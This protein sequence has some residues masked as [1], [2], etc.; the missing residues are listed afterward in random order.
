MLYKNWI[1]SGFVHVK[2]LYIDGTFVSSDHVFNSLK[3]RRN[4]IIEYK[5]VKQVIEKQTNKFDVRTYASHEYVRK[6][7]MLKCKSGLYFIKDQKSCFLYKILIENKYERPYTEK[8]W[9]RLLEKEMLEHDWRN[10]Y[11]CRIHS[12][13]DNKL[14]GFMNTLIHNLIPCREMLVKWKKVTNNECPVC[15]V[16]ETVEHIYFE[17]HCIK[18]VWQAIGSKL[19]ID[20]TWTKVIMGYLLDIPVH[21]V[22]N[23]LF[24]MILYTRYKLWSRSLEHCINKRDNLVMLLYDLTQWNYII[25]TLDFDKNHNVFKAIWKKMSL[26]ECIYHNMQID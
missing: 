26:H 15:K 23:L 6:G 20:I 22:R 24:T 14:K 11:M 19:N 25:D 21:R 17:C 5:N 10:I 12:L 18:Y 1:E 16:P 7:V 13:P 4:W 9:A 2:D 8:R 3:D